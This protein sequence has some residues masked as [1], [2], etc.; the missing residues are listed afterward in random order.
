MRIANLSLTYYRSGVKTISL[1]LPK[2]LEAQLEAEA[3]RRQTTK[4]AVVR[5]CLQQALSGQKRKRA[6]TC[7]DLAKDIIG[8]QRGPRDL[9]TNS[10]YMEGFGK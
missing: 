8:S 6:L 2:A 7:Y 1:K 10:K 9:S 5:E 3:R 4:S